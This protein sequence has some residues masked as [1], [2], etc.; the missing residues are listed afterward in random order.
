MKNGTG[1]PPSDGFQ[2]F[3]TLKYRA[4]TKTL[5]PALHD[6]S[7]KTLWSVDLDPR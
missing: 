4:K 2:F 3:G 1:A 5:T 6:L 7:G